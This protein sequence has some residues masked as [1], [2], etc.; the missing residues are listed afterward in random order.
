MNSRSFTRHR[1]SAQGPGNEPEPTDRPD[2]QA[3]R[4]QAELER[5]V[6]G[7]ELR[8]LVADLSTM[9]D[10]DLELADLVVLA[11]ELVEHVPVHISPTA[12]ARIQAAVQDQLPQPSARRQP[13]AGAWTR[14][15]PRLIALSLAV[16]MVFGS[17][18]AA[19]ANSLP[20]DA[21]YGVKRLAEEAR[22]ALVWD[23][24]DRIQVHR[25]LA[26]ARLA[27]IRALAS[28]H[29]PVPRSVALDLVATHQVLYSESA[30]NQGLLRTADEM[31]ARHEAALRQLADRSDQAIR[32]TLDET[33]AELHVLMGAPAPVAIPP[34]A[35]PVVPVASSTQTAAPP[36]TPSPALATPTATRPRPPT[37]RIPA[38][39]TVPP[40]P[41]IQVGSDQAQPTREH[42]APAPTPASVGATPPPPEPTSAPVATDSAGPPGAPSRTRDIATEQS[43]PTKTPRPKRPRQP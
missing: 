3:D 23:K 2:P 33:A 9:P 32:T 26:E 8:G 30:G 34:T 18:V 15:F 14:L 41:T 24:V 25:E 7:V 12:R 21:L 19:S 31:V 11:A 28:R 29:A 4:L 40:Q 20:G 22:L 1:A 10:A 17:A 39:P 13:A 42:V 38:H 43:R 35:G 37:A 27:E 6:D 36:V 16:A 5:L